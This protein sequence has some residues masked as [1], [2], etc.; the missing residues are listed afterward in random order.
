MKKGLKILVAALTVLLFSGTAMAAGSF[1]Y[2][3]PSG[4]VQLAMSKRPA[5]PPAAK[6]PCAMKNPCAA[7]PCSAKNPCAM[8]NPCAAN[9]CAVKNPCGKNPCAA[10]PC[11]ANPCAVKNPCGKK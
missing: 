3:E 11:A 4:Y 7:N 6:N 9:P 1:D 8:K 10:N 2:G 5:V